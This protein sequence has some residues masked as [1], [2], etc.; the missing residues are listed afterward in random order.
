MNL[1]DLYGL[2]NQYDLFNLTFRGDDIIFFEGTEAVEINVFLNATR[3]FEHGHYTKTIG[4]GITLFRL[5]VRVT[6]S[7]VITVQ[8]LYPKRRTR[9]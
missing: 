5:A 7:D 3:L 6:R 8:Y 4:N 1:V 2:G 9:S